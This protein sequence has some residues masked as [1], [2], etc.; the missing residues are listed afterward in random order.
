MTT[1]P[2]ADPAGDPIA[3]LFPELETELAMTRSML[4]IVPWEHADWKPHVRS[5]TLR[6]LATHVAQLPS[7]MTVMA[8][9]D[10]LDFKP[11][12]FTPP[13]IGSTDE[14]LALFDAECGRMSAALV[15]MDWSRL[16]GSWKMMIGEHAVIDNQRAM[17]LRH[18]GVNHLVHHRAQLGVFL[19]LLDVKIPG[20]YGPSADFA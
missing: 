1:H 16:N 4:A 18:M 11:E 10:T 13:T 5:M 17:L 6:A 9:T 8:A 12:D 14:L 7:F 15:G 20:C 19:R 2:I 3:L